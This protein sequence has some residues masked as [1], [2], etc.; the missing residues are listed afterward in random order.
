MTRTEARSDDDQ[1]ILRVHLGGRL[2]K[3]RNHAG[4]D[5]KSA[6]Q[7]VRTSTSTLSRIE[8][9]KQSAKTSFV[10]KWADLYGVPEIRDEL[11]DLAERA[12]APTWWAKY[13]AGAEPWFREML[14]REAIGSEI[15][16]FEVELI[17]GLLQT[18]GYLRA[19]RAAAIPDPV[20]E[21]TVRLINFRLARQEHLA[22]G[23]MPRVRFVLNEAV[24]LR[25]VG[26]SAVWREQLEALLAA[27]A[28]PEIDIRVLPFSAGPHPAM[29]VPFTAITVADHVGLDA[30]YLENDRTG[31]ELTR[32]GE[33]H[34]YLD[35]FERLT[36]M[37][38]S[39]EQSVAYIS[40]L[41]GNA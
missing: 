41:A 16:I 20:E 39:P 31:R 32:K 28:R 24:L 34:H 21:E 30:V 9:G 7:H 35:I 23:G 29:G 2:Q 1:L 36:S 4:I 25:P 15:R 33:L 5:M 27:A 12:S 13:K 11:V 18:P 14:A 40:T 3:L 19:F 8:N 26:S 22:D 38:W 10:R 6:A 37:S 17:H